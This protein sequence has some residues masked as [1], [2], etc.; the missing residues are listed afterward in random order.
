[1]LA[2][3]KNV[4]KLIGCCR[5]AHFKDSDVNQ[6]A[7]TAIS[8]VATEKNSTFADDFKNVIESVDRENDLKL[9]S[10]CLGKVYLCLPTHCAIHSPYNLILL[11]VPDFL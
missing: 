10:I 5:S 11:C 3:A 2:N 9:D 4:N 6:R 8:E 7:C 1:M